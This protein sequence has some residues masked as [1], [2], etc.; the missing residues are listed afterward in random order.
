MA[1]IAKTKTEPITLIIDHPTNNKEGAIARKGANRSKYILKNVV[2]A[3]NIMRAE[4][5][6]NCSKQSG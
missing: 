4:T 2:R 6:N 1:N 3:N 5:N